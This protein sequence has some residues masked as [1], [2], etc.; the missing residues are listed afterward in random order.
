MPISIQAISTFYFSGFMKITL[1]KMTVNKDNF[2]PT[3]CKVHLTRNHH[4]YYQIPPYV[5]LSIKLQMEVIFPD[6]YTSEMDKT[7]E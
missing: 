4:L 5:C 7:H 3:K 2:N 1:E 6:E